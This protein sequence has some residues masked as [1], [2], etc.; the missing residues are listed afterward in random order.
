[1]RLSENTIIKYLN[2]YGGIVCEH[3][4]ELPPNIKKGDYALIGEGNTVGAVV[5]VTEY[6]DGSG[7]VQY[8][9]MAEINLKKYLQL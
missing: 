2:E 5:N 1:M 7:L 4:K 3:F 8:K 9:I 6:Q